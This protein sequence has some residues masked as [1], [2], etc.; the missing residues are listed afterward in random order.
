MSGVEASLTHIV[1]C[2][3]AFDFGVLTQSKGPKP[4]VKILKIMVG[5]WTSE[6]FS[7]TALWSYQKKTWVVWKPLFSC[8][9][10]ISSTIV[11][12]AHLCQW[13]SVVISQFCWNSR[14]TN[15]PS[16]TT[17]ELY[18]GNRKKF[19]STCLANVWQIALRPK[20]EAFGCKLS[21]YIAWCADISV[22]LPEVCFSIEGENGKNSMTK[23]RILVHRKLTSH[24][25]FGSWSNMQ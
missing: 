9:V 19:K 2:P 22:L 6:N 21:L 13:L 4:A 17:I 20:F 12:R 10:I 1:E 14:W 15:Q 24:V 18:R 16:F 23:T 8:L 11:S 3:M 5:E 7:F 25:F